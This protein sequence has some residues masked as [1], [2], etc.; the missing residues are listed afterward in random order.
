MG[1]DLVQI[2][3]A[4]NIRF[5]IQRYKEIW[6]TAAQTVAKETGR[7]D[8]HHAKRLAVHF[9]DSPDYGRV[10][11]VLFL[12]QTIA[13]YGDWRS[14]GLIIRIRERATGIGSYAE[15]AEVI[16]GHEL[17]WIALRCLRAARSPDAK[18]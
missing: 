13:H 17:A 8:S 12:P 1:V 11:S 3:V 2:G 6:W 9:K 5:G 14:I 15:H 16:A 4:L 7:S 10:E 18:Q